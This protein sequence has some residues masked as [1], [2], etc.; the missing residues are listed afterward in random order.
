MREHIHS[1]ASMT[2]GEA[3]RKMR[4][5]ETEDFTSRTST[6]LEQ[7]TDQHDAV[8]VLFGCGTSVQDEIAAH[9]WMLFATTAN[10]SEMHR[11]VATQEH[12]RAVSG[13]GHVK[14]MSIWLASLPRIIGILFKSLRMK[15]RVAMEELSRLKSQSLTE[16]RQE[17][18]IT[19]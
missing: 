16:I 7:L 14:L 10:L 18:G 2:L 13:I 12:G 15:K 4:A 9:V 11:A 6:D 5:S 8:H 17:H 3:I 19:L 1:D